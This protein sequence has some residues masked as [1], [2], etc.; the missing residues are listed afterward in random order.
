MREVT[1]PPCKGHGHWKRKRVT[2]IFAVNVSVK[3]EEISSSIL[4]FYKAT[5]YSSQPYINDNLSRGKFR[6]PTHYLN[7]LEDFI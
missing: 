2:D 3:G 5:I 7:G 6:N 1:M 4:P